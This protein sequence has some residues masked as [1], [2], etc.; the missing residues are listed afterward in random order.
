MASAGALF[1]FGRQDGDATKAFRNAG[2][3]LLES[4]DTGATALPIVAT[5]V[6]MLHHIVIALV[7]G[8]LLSL[9]VRRFQGWRFALAAL[10][11]AVVF[12]LLNFWVVPPAVG[13]GYAVVTSV[14]RTI[15]LALAIAVALLV[16]PW[17]SGVPEE[18]ASVFSGL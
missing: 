10:V 4:R 9:I 5:T 12:V 13:I 6:G 15:P 17:A 2:R 7:W 14:G 8:M 16:T 1:A 3:M 11:T 18:R